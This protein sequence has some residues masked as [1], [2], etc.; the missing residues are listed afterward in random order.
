[1]L[2]TTAVF[3][4]D[5]Q[6]ARRPSSSNMFRL[7][8]ILL[9]N[10]YVATPNQCLLLMGRFGVWGKQPVCHVPTG[11]SKLHLNIYYWM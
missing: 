4:E 11:P 10:I 5:L 9:G 3:V 8:Q 6:A 7:G 1:M 2:L